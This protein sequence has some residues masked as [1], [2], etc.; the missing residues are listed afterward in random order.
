MVGHGGRRRAAL[1]QRLPQ[2]VVQARAAGAAHP[3]VDRIGHQGVRELVGAADPRLLPDQARAERAVDPADQ[4]VFVQVHDR[5]HVAQLELQP[6]DRSRADHR[7]PVVAEPLDALVD[8]LADRVG[9]RVLAAA[10]VDLAQRLDD[11][12]RVAAGPAL[13]AVGQA[14]VGVAGYEL[15]DL[16][17]GERL[18]VDPVDRLRAPQ[19]GDQARQLVPGRAGIAVPERHHDKQRLGAQPRRQVA[20]QRQPAGVGP[21][22][23]V[24]DEQRGALRADRLERRAGR[25][26]HPVARQ[27]RIGV[28]LGRRRAVRRGQARQHPSQLPGVDVGQPRHRQ[29]A[30]LRRALERLGERLVAGQRLLRAAAVQ[31]RGAGLGGGARGLGHQPC[32]AD[33]G[34]A[35]DRRDPGV[36]RRGVLPGRGQPL[37]DLLPAGERL[38]GDGGQRSGQHGGSRGGRPADGRGRSRSGSPLPRRALVGQHRVDRGARLR[39][40]RDAQL[41]AQAPP[42]RVR[43]LDGG[44]AVAGLGQQPHQ[45]GLRGLRERVGGRA[46]ARPAHGPGRVALGLRRGRAAGEQLEQVG[47]QVVAGGDHPLLVVLGQ[48]HEGPQ[49]TSRLQVA[50]GGPGTQIGDVDRHGARLEPDLAA[51]RDQRLRPGVAE[52]AAEQPGRLPQAPA[53]VLLLHVGPQHAGQLR[54]PVAAGVKGQPGQQG[55]GASRLRHRSAVVVG[56]HGESSEQA[57]SQHRANPKS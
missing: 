14:R 4:G 43:D 2:P 15:G 47:A 56:V 34:L 20:E 57:D 48:Q 22:H 39:G 46:L 12:Q 33:A 54:P 28:R 35:D 31:D 16:P 42:Q 32:L 44:G 3:A 1:G 36:A 30:V 23:V 7:E 51:G 21:V 55:A 25:V 24:E 45:L 50:G 27:L 49:R 8:Q 26:E 18:Q 37:R 10:G 52:R 40:R 38:G 9:H 11:E 5:A 13:D 17:G 29:Q 19:L 41:V 53:R 6:R